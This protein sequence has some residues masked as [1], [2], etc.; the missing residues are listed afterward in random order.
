[1][2]LALLVITGQRGG[3][4]ST[5]AATILVLEE[6][7]AV[8]DLIDQTL[9]G[10]GYRVLT[11]QNALEAIEVVR[12]V[13]IDVLVL[14]LL[15]GMGQT[16]VDEFRSIQAGMRI[17]SISDPDDDLDG[18]DRGASLS[19]PFSLDDLREAAAAALGSRPG[20]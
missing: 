7:A 19:G 3:L 8:Q 15:H 4:D 11:T 12:R 6:N 16:L 2:G 5:P 18:I 1:L 20:G 14:G 17:V 10:S 9:R 13:R